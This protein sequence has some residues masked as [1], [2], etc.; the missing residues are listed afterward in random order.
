VD[1]ARI[2]V[3]KAKI[4]VGPANITCLYV[5][6]AI[7]LKINGENFLHIICLWFLCNKIS[8]HNED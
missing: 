6:A 2:T 7:S 1:I 3:I 8:I 5:C 4:F